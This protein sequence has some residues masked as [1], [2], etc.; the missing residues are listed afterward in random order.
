MSQLQEAGEKLLEAIAYGDAAG[1]PVETLSHEEIEARYG[2]ITKLLP[3]S[4]NPFFETCYLPGSWSDDTQLSLAIAESLVEVGEFNLDHV[5]E[6]HIDAYH[7]TPFKEWK[8]SQ[9]KSGWGNSTQ[10]SIERIIDGKSPL[11]SGKRDGVGN[12]IL[13]KMSPLIYFQYARRIEQDQRYE[14]YDLLT[15]MTHDS[16]ITRNTSKLHGDVVHWLMGKTNFNKDQVAEYIID[17]AIQIDT[18]LGKQFTFLER[19]LST[20]FILES[21]DSK[22]FYAPQTLAMAYGAFL[23]HNAGFSQSVYE[24]VNLGGDTDSIASIVASMSILVDPTNSFPE[25]VSLIENRN[26]LK[27]ISINLTKVALGGF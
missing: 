23:L 6:K 3:A 14:E 15:N 17:Q 7:R 27:N 22:G 26:Y 12:G 11:N 2:K 16:E 24:A 21:T 4:E 10:S 19:P 9:I 5:A 13:M 1:L 25:D 20:E 8:G 18:G